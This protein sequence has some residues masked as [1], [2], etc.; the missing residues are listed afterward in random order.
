MP[1]SGVLLLA[2]LWSLQRTDKSKSP[3]GEKS[4][5]LKQRDAFEIGATATPDLENLTERGFDMSGKPGWSLNCD[6]SIRNLRATDRVE[7]VT[8][9]IL[10]IEPPMDGSPVHFP[11]TQDMTLRRAQFSFIDI[12]GKSLSGDQVGHVRLFKAARRIVFMESKLD[13]NVQFFGSWPDG[14]NTQFVARSEHV[15]ILE[16]TGCGVTTQKACFKLSFPTASEESVLRIIKLSEDNASKISKAR[17]P[18]EAIDEAISRGKVLE[19]VFASVNDS[20]PPNEPDAWI[21]ET[22]SMLRNHA[23]DYVDRFNEAVTNSQRFNNFPDRPSRPS[24]EFAA[25]WADKN[26]RAG[27]DVIDSVLR[28]LPQVRKALYSKLPS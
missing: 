28:Y 11:R 6:I 7:D 9:R 20:L 3:S 19:G 15:L 18:I 22:R 12:T 21:E 8:L 5:A 16:V 25:W 14:L 1:V 26:R 23:L 24:E 4:D 17:T 27:W 10:S 2:I 13:T